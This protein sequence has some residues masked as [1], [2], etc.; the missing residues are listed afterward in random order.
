[1]DELRTYFLEP[2]RHGLHAFE[3]VADIFNLEVA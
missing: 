3:A 2:D 1:M